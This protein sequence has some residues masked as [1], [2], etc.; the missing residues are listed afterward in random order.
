MAGATRS[1]CSTRGRAPSRSGLPEFVLP[2]VG[3]ALGRGSGRRHGIPRILFGVGTGE[4]LGTMALAGAE[5]MGVDFRVPLDAA[6]G[7]VA[8][9]RAAGQPRSC[10][11]AAGGCRRAPGSQHPRGGPAQWSRAHLQPGSRRPSADRSGCPDPRGRAGARRAVGC[12]E[13]ARGALSGRAYPGSR[14]AGCDSSGADGARRPARA[15]RGIGTV[16]P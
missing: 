11:P 10:G 13:R 4:L 16:T 14:R 5:V 1:S 8:R 2:H 6:A 9:H 12:C 7:R 15:A 3:T